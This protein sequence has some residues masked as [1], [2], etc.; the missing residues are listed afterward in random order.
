[1][2]IKEDSTIRKIGG[3]ELIVIPA[4]IRSDSTYPV[5]SDEVVVEIV[6]NTLVIK[7]KRKWEVPK[8]QSV[9]NM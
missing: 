1:M 2:S 6:E 4:K 8:K 7:D 5:K 9:R 3:S